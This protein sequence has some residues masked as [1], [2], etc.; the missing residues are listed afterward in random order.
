MDT[1]PNWYRRLPCDDAWW[2]PEAEEME[3]GLEE[4]FYERQN[5]LLMREKSAL[6]EYLQEH[7]PWVAYLT[8]KGA[9]KYKLI[10]EGLRYFEI[11]W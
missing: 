10:V 7:F 4:A 8:V 5:L 3:K 1:K 6:E 11:S 9:E 2:T